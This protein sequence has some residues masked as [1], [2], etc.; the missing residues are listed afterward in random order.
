MM[1]HCQLRIFHRHNDFP[2]YISVSIRS[3]KLVGAYQIS[4]QCLWTANILDHSWWAQVL[5]PGG[6]IRECIDVCILDDTRRSPAH[7]CVNMYKDRI[8]Q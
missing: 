1:P 6:P 5:G 2:E 7:S 3:G 8:A 4:P